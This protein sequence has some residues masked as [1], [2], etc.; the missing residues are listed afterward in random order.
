MPKCGGKN[1]MQRNEI[2]G[3]KAYNDVY[4]RSCY[5]IQI[6]SAM[7]GIGADQNDYLLSYCCLPQENFSFLEID[8]CCFSKFRNSREYEIDKTNITLK[9]LLKAI[10]NQKPV[11]ISVDCY[12]LESRLETYKQYHAPHYILVYGYDI[13][14]REVKVIDH[15]HRN[16]WKYY[17]KIISLDNLLLANKMFKKMFAKELKTDRIIYK[18]EIKQKKVTPW[19][20]LKID[21]IKE[22]YNHSRENLISFKNLLVN[23]SENLVKNVRLYMDYFSKLKAQYMTFLNTNCILNNL[24]EEI[25]QLISCYNYFQS[26]LWKIEFQQNLRSLEKYSSSILDKLMKVMTIEE[27][28]HKHILEVRNVL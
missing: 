4:Y 12:Y 7:S 28:L 23:R 20:F 17:E 11:L 24:K 9:K 27:I 13:V 22:S 3:V 10:D 16:S 5:Y 21:V 19:D 1:S 14:K 18:K 8:F 6:L 25:L 26:L 2:K 15:D